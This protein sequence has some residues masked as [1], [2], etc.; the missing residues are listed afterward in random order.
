MAWTSW[1][2]EPF[3]GTVMV[4]DASDE[5]REEESRTGGD[6]NGRSRM[7]RRGRPIKSYIQNA[8]ETRSGYYFDGGASYHRR[9]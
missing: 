8:D 3:M 6:A 9:V 5:R 1:L 7:E 4:R 2:E